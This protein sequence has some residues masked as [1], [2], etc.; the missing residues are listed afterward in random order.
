MN[1]F[2]KRPYKK[3]DV[4]GGAFT[5]EF[6]YEKD[7][8]SWN[9]CYLLIKAKNG[10]FEQ[11]VTGFTFGYLL[12]SVLSGNEKELEAYCSMM[13]RITQEIYKY[14]S[15]CNGIIRAI[16]RHDRNLIR[17]ASVDA[18]NVSDIEESS[19]QSFFE[20]ITNPNSDEDFRKS[21]EEIVNKI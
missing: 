3:L 19:A 14:R 5:A 15:L 20:Y 18:K 8:M 2:K 1:V 6:F 12:S 17:K 7:N 21:V 16:N 9:T 4:C 10:V 13:W 11:K